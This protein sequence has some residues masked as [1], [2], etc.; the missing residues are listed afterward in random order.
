MLL[1]HEHIYL[2]VAREKE[3]GRERE[4]GACAFANLPSFFVPLFWRCSLLCPPSR[5]IHRRHRLSMSP[6]ALLTSHRSPNNSWSLPQVVSL[7]WSSVSAVILSGNLFENLVPWSIWPLSGNYTKL[8]KKFSDL[9]I[10]CLILKWKGVSFN[11]YLCWLHIL[12]LTFRY[13]FV[14]FFWDTLYN[15]LCTRF[16]VY[17]LSFKT[18]CG[19]FFKNTKTLVGVSGTKTRWHVKRVSPVLYRQFPNKLF[20][21]EVIQTC[22]SKLPSQKY[23]KFNCVFEH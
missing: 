18:R 5:S 14:A 6:I 21:F 16:D 3:R 19:G 13:I 8:C 4:R 23:F 15:T 20:S 1:R 11:P 9:N 22:I 2:Q 12:R 17:F 7:S 10:W